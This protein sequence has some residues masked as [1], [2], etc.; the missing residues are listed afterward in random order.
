MLGRSQ[1][2][3]T[4]LPANGGDYFFR[5]TFSYDNG[6]VGNLTAYVRSD[7]AATVYLNGVLLDNDTG[8]HAGR[9]WNRVIGGMNSLF[10]DTFPS[11]DA[12]NWTVTGGSLGD[13]ITVD[14]MCGGTSGSNALILRWGGG[15]VTSREVDLSGLSTGQ[16]E[17]S[18][19]Q[20]GDNNGC[21]NPES[22]DDTVVEYLAANGSWMEL[23][24]HDGGGSDPSEGSWKSYTHDI[25]AADLHSGFKLRFAEPTG[26][27]SDYDYWAVDDVSIG[28]YVPFNHSPL[29]DGTNV[30]AARLKD[31]G[32]ERSQVRT[33]TE[34]DWNTGTFNRTTT[35]GEGNL[36]LARNASSTKGEADRSASTDGG[37]WITVNLQ[38]SYTNPIVFA[39]SNTENGGQSPKIGKVRNVGAS[40]FEAKMCEH[41]DS[42]GGCDGHLDENLGYAAFER[43]AIDAMDGVEAGTVTLSGDGTNDATTVS[44]DETFS[45]TPVVIAA[46]QTYNEAGE[47]VVQVDNVGTSSAELYLCDHAEGSENNCESHGSETVAWLAVEPGETPFIDAEAGI[48]QNIHDSSW[49]AESFSTAFDTA[50]A[51]IATIQTNNGG[52]QAKPSMARSVTTSGM[53][54][55]YCEHDGGDTCDS[56]NAEDVGWLAFEPRNDIGAGFYEFGNYTS[57]IIDAGRAVNWTDAVVAA[58]DSTATG[59]SIDFS[60]NTTWYD[61]VDAVPD[62]RY[63]R[64]NLSLETSDTARTPRIDTVN[65]SYSA[66]TAEFDLALNATEDRRRSMIVMSDGDANVE[67]SMTGVPDHDGDGDVDAKDHT[68]EAGCRAN[69]DHNTTVYAVGFGSDADNQTLN[70]TAECGGG[71]YYFSS[72]GELKAI[73][74]NISEQILEASFAGQTLEVA[75]SGVGTLHPDSY[76]AFNYTPADRADPG[77]FDLTQQ[78]PRFGGGRESPKNGSFT[79]PAGTDVLDA[80]VTSYSSNF[81][82]DRVRIQNATGYYEYA[83]RLWRYDT[84]YRD[85]GDPYQVHIPEDEVLTGMN[86]VSV[87]TGLN[88]TDRTGGSPDNR[89][90]YTVA[91]D[92]SVGYGPAFGRAAGGNHTFETVGGNVTISVG[93]ATDSWNASGDALDN[94]TAR[95]IG[96]LDLDGDG[97]V[98]V[99]VDS[100]DLDITTQN[101][102]G[103]QWLWGPATVSLEVWERE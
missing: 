44:F 70:L 52:Q 94:A 92:G 80:L 74:S 51:V 25:P 98:D 99:T 60:D 65:L 7:D 10:T 15:E 39:T 27:G 96:Q 28:E 43:D 76:L 54:I 24:T 13:E 45:S 23:R 42:D 89:V 56:H 41:E 2:A 59:Y 86:N 100:D 69:E 77:T 1:D 18:L 63:L 22:G 87:D 58:N 71:S 79:V 73:F 11:F 91:V 38:N 21:E 47:S 97:V 50:P 37:N 40:S 83:Y 29:R 16:V 81:W 34:S 35:D 64:F 88:R 32:S 95:L 62:S 19:K 33:E 57:R 6:S 5:R 66:V 31:D 72:T 84:D 93:N 3:A 8:D 12:D 17:Y 82:T 55:R 46:Q 49:T 67:T 30:L 26:S 14:T 103:I 85:L 48:T 9:Y 101:V 90:I 78:G 75:G 68:I 4:T 53:D 61:T 102:G 36:T 20:G